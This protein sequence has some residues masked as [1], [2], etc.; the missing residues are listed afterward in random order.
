MPMHSSRIQPKQNITV[1]DI[2]QLWGPSNCRNIHHKSRSC[3]LIR[4]QHH[5]I[6]TPIS[7]HML[8]DKLR[9]CNRIHM[10]HAIQCAYILLSLCLF[11]GWRYFLQR[12]PLLMNTIDIVCTSNW[13]KHTQYYICKYTYKYR[14]PQHLLANHLPICMYV[15]M[16]VNIYIY[17]QI[18][19][20]SYG[21]LFDP[22]VFLQVFQ[23]N[24]AGKA[25]SRS[26][27]HRP[28]GSSPSRGGPRSRPKEAETIGIS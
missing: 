5:P 4:N 15:C 14:Y 3:Y 13:Q 1:D 21:F 6:K 23:L 8:R 9:I 7:I 20:L 16:Y 22:H 11:L 26:L 2:C 18:H 10:C 25:P 28:S 19:H 12:T 27:G 24:D 17:I